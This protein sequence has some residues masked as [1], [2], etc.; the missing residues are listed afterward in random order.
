MFM[1]SIFFGILIF[2]L[3]IGECGA[4]TANL[5]AICTLPGSI[6]EAS[7]IALGANSTFWIH[8]DS[9]SKSYIYNIDSHCSILRRVEVL[10]S[11][12]NDWEDLARDDKGNLYIAD[13]GNNGNARK[14]LVIY[15][16]P[17]PDAT[18]PDT[19]RAEKIEFTYEDQFAFPPAQSGLNFDAEALVWL[20]DSL[21]IFSKNRTV[22]YTGY[23]KMYVLPDK[24]GKYTARLVDSLYTGPSSLAGWITAADIDLINK[25]LILLSNRKVILVENFVGNNPLS[26]TDKTISFSSALSQYEAVCFGTASTVYIAE[27]KL[28]T[29]ANVYEFN[30]SIALGALDEI[31]SLPPVYKVLAGAI[32]IK[33]GK[34]KLKFISLFDLLG[35][36]VMDYKYNINP[37]SYLA[38]DTLQTGIYILRFGYQDSSVSAARVFIEPKY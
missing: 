33:E 34:K 27:E 24:S 10:G 23:T 38:T 21:Y 17:N 37:E 1:K 4:Q 14:D 20:G 22:P 18:I 9:G 7:G 25:H 5:R 2:I 8:N 28:S 6:N 30:Y 35:K 11:S 31:N 19:I 36:K 32:Y 29:Q 15:K 16:V 12:Q 26:G 13:I 3:S